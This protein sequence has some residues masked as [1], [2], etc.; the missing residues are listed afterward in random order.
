MC[1]QTGAIELWTRSNVMFAS[2][3]AATII[4]SDKV[5]KNNR[6]FRQEDS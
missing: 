6:N 5:I 4:D 2:K 1:Y 3:S